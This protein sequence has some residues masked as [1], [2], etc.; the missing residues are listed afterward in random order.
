MW[1]EKAATM[2][3]EDESGEFDAMMNDPVYQ[4]KA[5]IAQMYVVGGYGLAKDPSY[6]GKRFNVWHSAE[7]FAV[8][9]ISGRT[10]DR[11]FL[12]LF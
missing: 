3:Q 12:W 10:I 11:P 7:A 4:I 5:S 8:L 2:M 6:A 1:Y 9:K